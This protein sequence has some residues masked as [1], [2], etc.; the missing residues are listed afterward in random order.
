MRVF[1]ELM[2]FFRQHRRRYVTGIVF[3]G[4]TS[5][6]GLIPP[7]IVGMVVNRVVRHQVT[8]Q[9]L[10]WSLSAIFVVAVLS[11]GFRYLWRTRLYGGAILLG[12]ELRDR[13][14]EHF[15]TLSPDFYHAHRIGDLMAHATNDVQAIQETAGDGVFMMVD[16]VISGVVVIATMAIAISWPLTI[17]A[18]LPLPFLAV[19]MAYYGRLLHERFTTAQAAFSDINDRVQEYISG[20]RVVRAFGQEAAEREAF[21]ALSRE[22]VEKNVAVARIDA[23][24]DPTIAVIAGLSYFLAVAVGAWF[25]VRGALTLGSLTAFTLYLGQLIW[26]MMAFGFVFNIVERGS[27]SYDRVK[28][29]LDTEATVQERPQAREIPPRG[30]LRYQIPHFYYPGQATPALQRIH[31][32]VREGWTLGI[33][34]RTG[35]GKTTLF[36]LL[37]REFDLQDGDISLGGESI[38]QYRLDALRSVIGYA[39]QD[40]FLFSLSIRDNIAFR[41]PDADDEAIVRVA[42]LA[43][44][45]DEILLLPE[46]YATMIGERGMT[47]SGGQKQRISLA[48][49]LLGDPPILALDDTLSSVDG[50]TEA[51]ILQHLR[52]ARENRTTLIASHRLSAVEHADE[53]IVLEGGGIVEQGTHRQLLALGGRYRDMYERQQLE[54]LVEQGGQAHGS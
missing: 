50:Q 35:A 22:V 12:T 49:A 4:L 33:V 19:I 29:L 39:P 45:H 21:V 23:L 26:P 24:F 43:A 16:A 41:D 51:E 30:D 52:R 42:K 3:L 37:L 17:V 1:R 34:G 9:F 32:A 18:L 11:Y 2:W 44:I 48:R 46:G 5:L 25:V 31:L 27:A 38:Y 54:R 8:P 14:F 47:L 36:R 28:Q 13:L 10:V 6:M 15:T 7:A 40:P 53:I 20:I